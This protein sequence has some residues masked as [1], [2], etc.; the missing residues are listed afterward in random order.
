MARA[1]VASFSHPAVLA[2]FGKL[3]GQSVTGGNAAPSAP[4]PPEPQY[5]DVS[6]EEATITIVESMTML[7]SLCFLKY[8]SLYF[9]NI[10][11]F[12]VLTSQLL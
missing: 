8:F 2:A 10:S 1:V 11:S 9:L 3:L 5:S 7:K 12:S 6:A 4:P